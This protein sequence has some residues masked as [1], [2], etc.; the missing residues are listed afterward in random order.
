MS[1]VL[2]QS[3]IDALLLAMQS[4]EVDLKDTNNETC[5]KTIKV[6]DFC[7]PNKFSK[8]QLNTITVIYE[9]FCR[10]LGTLFSGLLRIKVMAKVVS[11]DQFTYDE[12]IRSIPSPSILSVFSL[13]PLEGKGIMEINPI[14]GFSIIDRLFGGPGL[15]TFNGRP[16]TEIEK[17]VIQKMSEKVLLL[18]KDAWSICCEVNPFLEVIE[19]NPQ[20]TQVVS[21]REM[22]VIITINIKIGETEGL[23]NICLPCLMLEPIAEKLSTKFWFAGLSH[24]SSENHS[25]DLQKIVEKTAIPLAVVLGKSTITIRE[26]LEL[27]TGDV[28]PLEKGKEHNVEVYVDSKLKFYGKPGLYSKK[29]A[30]KIERVNHEGSD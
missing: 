24:S 29:L 26:L 7:R 23:I 2:S 5:N 6:Y 9:N 20:F 19:I 21:P 18:F 10:L 11:V 25:R 15:S 17:N 8:D 22:V 1:E 14:I 4:G 13:M 3:E 12:F 30:V 27:Q 16:L 28:I